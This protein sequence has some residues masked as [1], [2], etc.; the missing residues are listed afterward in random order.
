MP[1]YE[2]WSDVPAGLVTQT[3]VW[4]PLR[5]VTGRL[6]TLGHPTDLDP[7]LAVPCAHGPVWPNDPASWYAQWRGEL[8]PATGQ[9]RSAWP[10]GSADRLWY[11]LRQMTDTD[12]PADTHDGD[13]G[14]C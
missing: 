14:G 9:L 8:D 2:R 6:E 1:S 7:I 3:R 5:A 12:T 10:P 4:G 11:V 13:R